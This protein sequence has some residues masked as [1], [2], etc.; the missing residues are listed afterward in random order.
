VQRAASYE[1]DILAS[2]IDGSSRCSDPCWELPRHEL[3]H[4][5]STV[6]QNNHY[7]SYTPTQVHR[8]RC[9]C[10]GKYRK[11]RRPVSALA[12]PGK[13]AYQRQPSFDFDRYTNLRSDPTPGVRLDDQLLAREYNPEATYEFRLG[14]I[15]LATTGWLA[16][17]A[18]PQIRTKALGQ[19]RLT[20]AVSR[21]AEWSHRGKFVAYY[22]V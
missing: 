12:L 7:R 13:H 10:S 15:S 9:L 21:S 18:N 2:D 4:G 20:A 5:S 1:H 22:R 16:S 19:G 3:V 14:P 11:G 8:E 6:E 17:K